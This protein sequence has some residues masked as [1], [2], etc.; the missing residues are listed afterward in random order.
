MFVCVAVQ[1]QL[2]IND[3]VNPG[4][5]VLGSPGDS[6]VKH[7]PAMQDTQVPSLGRVD[8]L[9][10]EMANHSSILAWKI[11]WMVG[12]S[13]WGLKEL[14]RTEQL[15]LSLSGIIIIPIWR[16]GGFRLGKVQLSLRENSS[17]NWKNQQKL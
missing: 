10:K 5:I 7:R 11:T 1:S 6:V 9:E 12:Y 17:V 4:T 3:K 16:V 8:P 2:K 14:V 15:T 13:S